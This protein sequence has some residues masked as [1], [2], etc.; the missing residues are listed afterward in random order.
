MNTPYS[1]DKSEQINII[2]MTSDSWKFFHLTLSQWLEL[3]FVVKMVSPGHHRQMI[4]T[5]SEI[6]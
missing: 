2:K 5:K 1:A 3:K 4:F 6:Q